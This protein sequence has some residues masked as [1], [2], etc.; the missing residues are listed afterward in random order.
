MPP[1]SLLAQL[2]AIENHPPFEFYSCVSAVAAPTAVATVAAAAAAAI[3][4]AA[5]A[6]TSDDG[7]DDGD[8]SRTDAWLVAPRSAPA[9][10]SCNPIILDVAAEVCN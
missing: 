4:A 1:L 8:E 9:E 2:T 7:D 6:A 5:A 3:A 10:Y